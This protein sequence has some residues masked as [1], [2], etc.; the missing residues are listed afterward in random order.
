MMG[1][2]GVGNSLGFN[3]YTVNKELDN[4]VEGKLPLVIGRFDEQQTNFRRFSITIPNSAT[5]DLTFPIRGQT[6]S[7]PNATEVLTITTGQTT[8]GFTTNYYN[9]ATIYETVNTLNLGVIVNRGT[10]Y[11][12]TQFV[13]AHSAQYVS[14]GSA[15][16]WTMEGAVWNSDFRPLEEAYVDPLARLYFNIVAGTTDQVG[17][18][19][20]PYYL[21]MPLGRLRLWCKTVTEADRADIIWQFNARQLVT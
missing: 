9:Q 4:Y 6:E 19:T 13:G 11:V 15:Q 17:T 1:R 20:N 12:V 8:S 18:M 21:T 10:G 5:Q 7:N 14:T 3:Q 16:P 2:M